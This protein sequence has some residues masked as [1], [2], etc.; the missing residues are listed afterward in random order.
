M[1]VS[2]S[3]INHTLSR[4]VSFLKRKHRT[5]WC[6]CFWQNLHSLLSHILAS[7][8]CTN[9]FYY[10]CHDHELQWSNRTINLYLHTVSELLLHTKTYGSY[11]RSHCKAMH[12]YQNY[13]PERIM[14][15]FPTSRCQFVRFSANQSAYYSGWALWFCNSGCARGSGKIIIIRYRP[16]DSWQR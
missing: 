6:P 5:N 4:T 14:L 2:L 12:E 16:Y 3:I 7:I 15:P 11:G 9:K 1:K 8:H 13:K 10:L